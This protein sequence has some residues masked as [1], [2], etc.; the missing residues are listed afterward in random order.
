[1]D[2]NN[3]PLL[4]GIATC[5]VYDKFYLANN[6]ANSSY[7][8]LRKIFLIPPP[9]QGTLQE[10]VVMIRSIDKNNVRNN[11]LKQLSSITCMGKLVM[12]FFYRKYSEAHIRYTSNT[13][14]LDSWH[15]GEQGQA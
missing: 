3:I 1:M 11:L 8:V 14:I 10:V 6:F 15:G 4:H 12:I 5:T 9:M 13:I 2:R 7:F